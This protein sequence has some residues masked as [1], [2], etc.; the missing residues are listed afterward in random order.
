MDPLPAAVPGAPYEIWW[1]LE[2]PSTNENDAELDWTPVDT[3]LDGGMQPV[4]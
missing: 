3:K 2:L 1:W 4:A